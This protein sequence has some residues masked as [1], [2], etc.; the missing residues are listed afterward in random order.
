MNSLFGDNYFLFIFFVKHFELGFNEG[1]KSFK[2]L[3]LLLLV[4]NRQSYTAG[5]DP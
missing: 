3:T 1:V 2:K 5:W 4:L